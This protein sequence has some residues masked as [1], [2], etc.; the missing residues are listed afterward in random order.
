[1]YTGLG[2]RSRG[3]WGHLG[4]VFRV[5]PLVRG[6]GRRRPSAGSGTL[7][8]QPWSRAA[9]FCWGA[10]VSSFARRQSSTLEGRLVRPLKARQLAFLLWQMTLLCARNWGGYSQIWPGTD[11]EWPEEV[12]QGL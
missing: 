4:G 7:P 1:M 2:P 8:T 9:A 11:L 10:P 3:H 6:R 5:L 12:Q